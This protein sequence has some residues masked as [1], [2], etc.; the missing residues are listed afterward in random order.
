MRH[1]PALLFALSLPLLAPAADIERGR[2]IY[3]QIC[4]NCQGPKLDGGQGPSL[5]GQY[6]QHGS[7]PEAILNVINK[8]VPGSPMIPYEAVFPESDRIALRDFIGSDPPKNP[9][10][11]QRSVWSQRFVSRGPLCC[12]NH[13]TLPP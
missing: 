8:G 6:W 9:V 7:S 2:L 5:K 1:F 10:S 4:F 3:S 12:S 11:F 13:S